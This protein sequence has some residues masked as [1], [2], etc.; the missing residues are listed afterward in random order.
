MTPLASKGLGGNHEIV[1]ELSELLVTEMFVGGPEGTIYGGGK[2]VCIK[3]MKNG[4]FHF[5]VANL[6]QSCF[7]PVPLMKVQFQQRWPGP[8]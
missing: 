6:L 3:T 8:Q 7:A 5:H 4:N 2:V 1:M